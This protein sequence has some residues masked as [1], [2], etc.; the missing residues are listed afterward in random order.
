[1]AATNDDDLEGLNEACITSHRSNLSRASALVYGTIM[2]CLGLG[3]LSLA[4]ILVD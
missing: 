4:L 2:A 3:F 1:M